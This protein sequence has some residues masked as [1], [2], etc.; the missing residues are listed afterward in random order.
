MENILKAADDYELTSAGNVWIICDSILDNIELS[1][2]RN[3]N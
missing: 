1:T 3:G 2:F